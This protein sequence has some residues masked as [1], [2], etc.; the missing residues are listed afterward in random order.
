MFESLPFALNCVQNTTF[1]I[2]TNWTH[3]IFYL[4][5]RKWIHTENRNKVN[6]VLYLKKEGY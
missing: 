6:K 2:P 3:T 1:E 4:K 5:K